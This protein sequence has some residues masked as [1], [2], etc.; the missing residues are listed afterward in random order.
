MQAL[1]ENETYRKHLAQR[2]NTQTIMLGFSDGTK[3]G[4]YLMANW[5]IYKAKEELTSLSRKYNIQV[6]F[7]DGRGGPPARGGGKTHQFYASMGRNIARKEIQ[8]TIQGQTVSSNFGNIDVANYN[9]EQLMH[10]GISNALFSPRE[11][12]LTAGEEEILQE[13][14]DESFES[15]NEIKTDPDFLEYLNFASPLR[16][17]AETNIGSRPS[18]RN[19]GKLNLNDLR[20]VPYVG[21]WSQLKQNLPGYYGLGTALMKLSK[22]GKWDEIK[23][24]YD[25]SLFFRTLIG[26]CEMAMQKCFFP[27]TSFLSNHPKYGKIWKKIYDEFECTRKYVLQLSGATEL[28][29]DKPVDQLSIE[30]RQRIELPLVTIQQY[31][32]TRIRE[33]DEDSPLKK[34]YEKLV[35]RCSF[36]IINAERNSA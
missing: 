30:M 19:N 23:A 34:T 26:N 1:Y 9:M 4:G 18:K 11:K 10:A 13:L 25:Q 16:Y 29:A 6:V 14:A 8:L 17:Y 32:L 35:M 2:N 31:A 36:G 33:L 12:T 20:A 28:M 22:A 7:F 27:L 21:A 3:D 24:L 15:F 5:S